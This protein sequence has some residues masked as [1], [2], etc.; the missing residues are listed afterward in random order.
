MTI[1]LDRERRDELRGMA[2]DLRRDGGRPAERLAD[3]LRAVATR[4]ADRD[5]KRWFERIEAERR[6]LVRSKDVLTRDG[7]KVESTVGAVAKKASVSPEHAWTLWQLT[8]RTG[9]SRVL[10]MGTCV[11]VSG[12]YLAAAAGGGR[13]A[14]GTLRTLEGHEDRAVVARDTFRRLGLED[15]QVVV[16]TFKRTLPGA[17]D[18]GPFDLVFVDGHH[19]GDATLRY[20]D[21]I[22][23]ASRPGAVLV[24]DDITWS[25]SMA[26]AWTEVQRRLSASAHADLGRVGVVV[27][28][29]EDAGS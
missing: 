11:G 17:L 4:R 23:A 28:G 18:A 14:G 13:P 9:A 19:D 8:R 16:G 10:E 29:A 7:G 20:V 5:T 2:R 1:V 15:A 3:G 26:A 22:R 12:S 6:R 24:L 21:Q 25:D 27:L